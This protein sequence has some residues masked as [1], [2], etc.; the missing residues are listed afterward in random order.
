[1]GLDAPSRRN[2][3]WRTSGVH[4]EL[5]AAAAERA[6]RA[7]EACGCVTPMGCGIGL[8]V[9][10]PP[11]THK[12]T[13]TAP[14]TRRHCSRRICMVCSSPR[15]R[16]RLADASGRGPYPRPSPGRAFAT[17]VHVTLPAEEESVGAGHAAWTWN[18]REPRA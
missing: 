8:A 18:P 13:A 12:R 3:G 6:D 17:V 14:V 4:G 5:V 1:M 9:A 2:S 7:I 11:A 10:A 16:P 15:E